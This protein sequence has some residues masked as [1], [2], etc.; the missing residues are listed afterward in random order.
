MVG[1]LWTWAQE[2]GKRHDPIKKGLPELRKL[3]WHLD[4]TLINIQHQLG[5]SHWFVIVWFF[6]Y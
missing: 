2:P 1:G 3:C 6:W 4:V 5:L